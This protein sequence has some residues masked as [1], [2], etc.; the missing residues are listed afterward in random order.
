MRD[1]NFYRIPSLGLC[2][3]YLYEPSM[4]V[5]VRSWCGGTGDVKIS[6]PKSWITNLSIVL[7]LDE[8]Q[9]DK[10]YMCCYL[11]RSRSRKS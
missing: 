1:P 11:G 2:D 9:A 7:E 10:K 6:P 8:V 5:V 4:L 3:E